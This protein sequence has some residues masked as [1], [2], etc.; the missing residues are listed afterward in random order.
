MA[1][2]GGGSES[3]PAATIER[4]VLECETYRR[5]SNPFK[6]PQPRREKNGPTA[7]AQRRERWPTAMGEG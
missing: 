2:C 7:H 3:V 6:E 5:Q 1:P 4:L